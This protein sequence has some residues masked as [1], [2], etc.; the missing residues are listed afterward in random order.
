MSGVRWL[1]V[2]VCVV[3]VLALLVYARGDRQRGTDTPEAHGVF[4]AV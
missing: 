4:I 1:V 3:L 2:L